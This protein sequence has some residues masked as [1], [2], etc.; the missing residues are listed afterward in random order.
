MDDIDRVFAR[1]KDDKPEPAD[2][3][4]TLSIPRRNGAGGSRTVEVVHVRSTGAPAS[5]GQPRRLTFTDRAATWE[6][7]F[8]ARP[9]TQPPAKVG[10]QPPTRAEPVT[11]VM[12]MWEPPPVVAKVTIPI[13]AEAPVAAASSAAKARHPATR[14]A[15][16]LFA[17][18]F[19]ASDD[20]ANCMRCGYAVEPTRARR[21]LMTCSAC[22]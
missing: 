22:A 8:P 2:R 13:C 1:F 15:A 4:E 11:H 5:K 3:R 21:G 16:K 17:D 19:D 7:G 9:S 10:A 12:P 20:G 6:N 14:K 18:P